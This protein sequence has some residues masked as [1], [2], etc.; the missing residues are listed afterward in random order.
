[1]RLEMPVKDAVLNK[2]GEYL[3]NKGDEAQYPN[4]FNQLIP[5]TFI[6][7]TMLGCDLKC[8]ECAIG[9]NRI[10]K[11]RGWMR[12]EQFKII[13]DKIRSFCRLLFLH[14]N[15][16]PMLNKD[17]FKMI[18][19]ASS[20]TAT[21]ISTNGQSL[22]EEKAEKLIKSGVTDI[23]VSIDGFSQKVYEQY[24]VGGSAG[25]ALWALKMLQDFNRKYGNKVRILPQY[26]VFKHNQHEM[27]L[28]R[29][30]CHSIHLQPFYKDPFILSGSKFE[31]A[32]NPEYRRP[33]YADI[34]SLRQAMTDC[35]T[36]KQDFTILLDG[37][38]VLCCADN[39]GLT[40]YGNI[41]EQDVL[42][43]WNSP[44]FMKDRWDIITGNAP[45]FCIENCL[46]WSL[47]YSETE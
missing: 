39:N 22:T 46:S 8:P 41:Y 26:I 40:N 3:F 36:P 16:E 37:T 19:Y 23:I 27:N 4:E 12:F 31:H 13:A 21:N 38:C 25:K 44:E 29:D 42:D 43:I 2:E 15:G 9:G 33:Y 34:A 10:T 14:H 35:L 32:D 5:I 18:E 17:I 47:R 11:K 28:F 24:R 30:F 1:M 45:E 20:F 7:E 6:V